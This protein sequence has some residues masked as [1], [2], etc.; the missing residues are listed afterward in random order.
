MFKVFFKQ[1]INSYL[2]DKFFKEFFEVK[3]EIDFEFY[4]VGDL[5]ENI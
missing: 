5:L 1:S 3:F 2:K 4:F